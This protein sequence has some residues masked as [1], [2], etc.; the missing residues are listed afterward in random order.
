M[1]L[2]TYERVPSLVLRAQ[3]D[4]QLRRHH[5]PSVFAEIFGYF[6]PVEPRPVKVREGS[7]MLRVKPPTFRRALQ[8]LEVTGYIRFT[9]RDGRGIRH[10]VLCH[11]RGP[12]GP[13]LGLPSPHA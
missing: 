12:V 11:E 10:Y 8:L 3:R 6:S 9:H 2:M 5:A 13:L 1:I 7:S 4:P